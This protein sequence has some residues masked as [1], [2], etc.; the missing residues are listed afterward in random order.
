MSGAAADEGG[1]LTVDDPAVEGGPVTG[2]AVDAVPP[3][4]VGATAVDGSAAVAEED[5]DP[6]DPPVAGDA[7]PADPDD[8]P[9]PASTPPTIIIADR[10]T[11]GDRRKRRGHRRR[12]MAGSSF[13]VGSR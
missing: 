4:A 11:T 12:R 1:E 9:Q 8:E 5:A 3:G 7:E 13:T 10:S 2:G 6:D